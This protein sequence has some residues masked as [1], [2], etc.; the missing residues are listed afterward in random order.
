MKRCARRRESV[1]APHPVAARLDQ[2]GSAQVGQVTRHGR[3]G[4]LER[5]YDVTDAD[6]FFP[7]QVEQPQPGLVGERAKHGIGGS[8]VHG[9]SV[10]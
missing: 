2:A 5:R 1:V 10:R 7:Q 3:L 6:L 8:C 9:D 4:Q